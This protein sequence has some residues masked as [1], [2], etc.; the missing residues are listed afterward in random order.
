[1]V[2]ALLLSPCEGKSTG[3][4][5]LWN[6]VLLYLIIVEREIVFEGKS[7]EGEGEIPRFLEMATF[8]GDNYV[9]SI[10]DRKGWMIKELRNKRASDLK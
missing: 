9:I 10:G 3:N 2:L 8:I 1:M 5:L 6:F 4:S 7:G